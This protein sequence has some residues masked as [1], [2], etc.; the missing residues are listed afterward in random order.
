[1]IHRNVSAANILLDERLNCRLSGFSKT[2]T[3]TS[4]AKFV[5]ESSFESLDARY[6]P[7]TFRAQKLFYINATDVWMFGR[8]IWEILTS[9]ASPFTSFEAEMDYRMRCEPDQPPVSDPE[10]LDEEC[11]HLWQFISKSCFSFKPNER[12][13]FGVVVEFLARWLEDL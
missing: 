11:E 5:T 12:V 10:N 1:M 8:C 3:I 4:D 6:P 2:L 7:E 9:G 13:K